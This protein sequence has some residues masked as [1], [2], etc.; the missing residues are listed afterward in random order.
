MALPKT[1]TKESRP[2]RTRPQ[3]Y[4]F[5]KRTLRSATQDGLHQVAELFGRKLIALDV[6]E[7]FPLAVNNCGMQRM[8]H[9][10]F[11]G[12]K[13]HAEKVVDALYLFRRSGKK[14]PRIRVSF[15]SAGI[16]GKNIWPV[17]GRIKGYRQ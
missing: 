4:S 11:V 2:R 3:A 12:E 6:G 5:G 15:P 7:Q 16:A 10:S 1:S 8:V 14:V 9:Q 17:S 13:I